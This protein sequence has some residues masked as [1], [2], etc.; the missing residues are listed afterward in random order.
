MSLYFGLSAAAPPAGAIC[1]SG[2]LLRS[3]P[4]PNLASLPR[5]LVHGHRD[6]TIREV[7]ARNSYKALLEDK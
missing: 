4:T 3:A 2:Y 5:L 7:E 6:S 1:L